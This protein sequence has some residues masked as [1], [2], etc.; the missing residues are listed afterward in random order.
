MVD[1]GFFADRPLEVVVVEFGEGQPRGDR[2]I[3]A[4]TGRR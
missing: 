1:G 3:M 4:E 2:P